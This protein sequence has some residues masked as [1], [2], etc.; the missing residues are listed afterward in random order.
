MKIKINDQ[1]VELNYTLRMYYIYENITG[2]SFSFEETNQFSSLVYLFFSCIVASIQKQHLNITFTFDDLWDLLDANPKL[3]QEFAEFF[4]NQQQHQVEL[5]PK[6][7]EK[8]A[9]KTP[10][11]K[12]S[13]N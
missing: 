4:V 10:K 6:E 13:K 8:K 1:E 2:K 11:A 5:S 3:T 9:K 12:K 7:D